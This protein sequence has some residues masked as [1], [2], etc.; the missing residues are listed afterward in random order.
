T[1][2]IGTMKGPIVYLALLGFVATS[3][4]LDCFVCNSYTDG[5]CADEFKP[6]SK[7]LQTAFLKTCDPKADNAT[8]DP[9]CRKVLMDAHNFTRI[10]RDCGYE[11]REDYDCY[12]KRSEDYVVTVCQC[13]ED[14]CNGANSLVIAPV[15]ALLVPLFAKWL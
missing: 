4:A 11:R 12:Q 8:S 7:A 2:H 9:F 14:N 10:Q 13:D 1:H 3:S 15:L 6:E 5:A